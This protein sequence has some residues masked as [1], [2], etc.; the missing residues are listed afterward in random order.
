MS[1]LF[2]DSINVLYRSR[3]VVFWMDWIVTLAVYRHSYSMAV[4]GM[5]VEVGAEA[6]AEGQ[7][8]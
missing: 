3:V 1:V 6:V 4:P 5:D 2:C 8:P 7:I